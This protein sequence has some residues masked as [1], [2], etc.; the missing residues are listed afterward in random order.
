MTSAAFSQAGSKYT[1][2]PGLR[3]SSLYRQQNYIDGAWVNSDSARTIEVENPATRGLIGTVPDSGEAETQRA[4]L[5]AQKAQ[6][7][8]QQ[9]TAKERSIVLKKWNDL[10]LQNI[11]D[12]ALILTTE[13]GKP[14]SEAKS[15]IMYGASFLEWFGEEAKRIYGDVIPTDKPDRRLFVFKQ[16][17]GVVGAI[18]P[19]NFPIAMITRKCAPAVAAGCSVVLKPSDLTPFSALAL[20]ALAER[21]GLPPG[22]LN[23]VTGQ[24]GPIGGVLTSSPIVR[25]I[26]FT[27]STRVGKILLAQSASSVKKVSLELGGHAPFIVFD[28]ANIERVIANVIPS[29][30]RNAGQT[31]VSA[32]RIYVQDGI[33]ESLC[34]ALLSLF[35]TLTL[36]SGLDPA[37]KIGPLINQGGVDKC[38]SQVQDAL[39]HN[40]SLLFPPHT[41]P[42]L[43][44][45]KSLSLSLYLAIYLSIYLHLLY[46]LT[47]W[48]VIF[49]RLF[50][51]VIAH[52]RC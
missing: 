6:V 31:C 25:K 48:V 52:P 17:I 12:L 42:A 50:Y 46:T 7:L 1:A 20:A 44:P 34:R 36:G 27:G 41:P 51:L 19:W 32:N 47:A 10:V 43:P 23:V 49:I 22:V 26:T 8:W 11:D 9:K 3:D 5:A 21:A 28:D 39:S 16:P 24:A 18:T 38:V 15:E 40:A 13:Q 30:F 45:S 29:K 14:L 35:P 2:I 4:I 33:Y 37:T